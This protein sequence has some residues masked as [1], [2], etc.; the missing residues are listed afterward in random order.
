MAKKKSVSR[1]SKMEETLGDGPPMGV[2]SDDDIH[3][4]IPSDP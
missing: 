3:V 1:R 2:L 4:D